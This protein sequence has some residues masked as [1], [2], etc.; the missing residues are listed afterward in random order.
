MT[1][2]VESVATQETIRDFYQ[3]HPYP[4]PVKSL[5][6]YREHWND[7]Q[8]RRADFH[9][10]EPT[11]PYREN[12]RILIAGCGTSQAAK[13]AVRWPN[14]EVVGIDVSSTSVEQTKQLKTKYALAN[15]EVLQLAVE[16]APD[17]GDNFDVVV[18]TGVLHHLPDPARGLRALREVL[19][20]EGYMHLMV[21]APSGRAGIYLL[22]DYC[23]RLG[24]EP[25]SKDISTLM[26]SLQFLPHDHPLRQLLER[27][28]D[29]RKEAS[30]ADALLNP[31]DQPFSVDQFM[32]FLEAGGLQF[33]RWVRQAE[34]SP[35]CGLFRNSPHRGIL[36]QLP[37]LEQYAAV[38]LFRGNLLRHSAVA[39][40]ND[41][42]KRR[43]PSS[44]R[45][46]EWESYIPLHAPDT[47]RVREKLPEGA[48][49]VLINPAHSQT[50]IYLPISAAQER[51]VDAIDNRRSVAEIAHK[52][53]NLNAVLELIELLWWHDLIVFDASGAPIQHRGV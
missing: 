27:S 7:P 21:Y 23:R 52:N 18:C 40:R 17:L 24:I 3:C 11:R 25:T 13:Y 20:P 37:E 32:A 15:L 1:R 29:F 35:R 34:Y 2:R 31:L 43:Q 4:P 45:L 6:R 39:Y 28:P 53:G 22:Q 30:I 49:A 14:S 36:D 41:S 44:I 10:F 48:S 50:D 26:E 5:D 8:R 47:V 46:S 19:V 51:I 38:E 33:S 12:R 16:Q 9:L 42:A